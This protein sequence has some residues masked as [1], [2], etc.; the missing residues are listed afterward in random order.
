MVYILMKNHVNTSLSLP[1]SWPG[2][3][4]NKEET[5]TF[6]NYEYWKNDTFLS[7]VATSQPLLPWNPVDEVDRGKERPKDPRSFNLTLCV[8]VSDW[9][10]KPTKKGIWNVWVFGA[11]R[12]ISLFGLEPR[13]S[14]TF[15]NLARVFFQLVITLSLSFSSLSLSPAFSLLGT[16]RFPSFW[17]PFFSNQRKVFIFVLFL[18]LIRVKFLDP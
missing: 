13:S 15:N 2:P 8:S 17:P 1:N 6:A 9:L 14:S 5:K 10:S 11:K 3:S 16:A 4:Q 12:V 7:P 18:S